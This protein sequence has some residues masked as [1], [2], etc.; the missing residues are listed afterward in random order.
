MSGLQ[1]LGVLAIAVVTWFVSMLTAGLTM[2]TGP[3]WVTALAW[4]T[5]KVMIIVGVVMI[6]YLIYKG[7]GVHF[8]MHVRSLDLG[9]GM[10]LPK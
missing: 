10:D 4:M 7:S 9:L 1:A 2:D 6:V 8:E 3:D 5:S